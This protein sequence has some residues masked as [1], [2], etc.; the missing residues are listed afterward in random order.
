MTN[1][2]RIKAMSVDEMVELL[3]EITDAC[4]DIGGGYHCERCPI[5]K[6]C[7]CTCCDVRRW[8]ESEC[9]E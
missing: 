4:A 5:G 6:V 9:D 2:E 7:H 1:Y 3:D 8:L